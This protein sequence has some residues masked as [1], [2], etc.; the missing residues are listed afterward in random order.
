LTGVGK[1]WLASALGH[2]ACRDNR[3]V[4][5]QRIPQTVRRPRACPRRWP[6]CPH[7]AGGVQ[8]L[9]LDDW[10]LQPLDAAA[11]HDLLDTREARHGRRMTTPTSQRP[12]TKAH[13]LR[14]PPPHAGPILDRPVHTPHCNILTGQRLRLLRDRKPSKYCPP[15]PLNA[16]N[17]Q[18]A[19]I[20]IL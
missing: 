15:P 2:K 6:L 12:L 8:L 17:C 5:Y 7:P 10:G 4:L 3:S 9:I 18:P 11:R 19:A 20:A 14:P 13:D 16:K 1:S